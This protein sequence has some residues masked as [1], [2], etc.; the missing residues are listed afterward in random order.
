MKAMREKQG[1][2]HF[3]K[4]AQIPADSQVQLHDL[5]SSNCYRFFEKMKISTE[6]LRLDPLHWQSSEAY[7]QAQQVVKGI[8]VV[9]DHAERAVSLIQQFNRTLTHDED[10]LQFLLQVVAKHR[11]EFQQ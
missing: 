5:A 10:Q 6:F 2:D 3:P 11:R 1:G 4:K 8:S 7:L 9:N